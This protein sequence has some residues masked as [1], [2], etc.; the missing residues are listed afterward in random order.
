[1]AKKGRT[2]NRRAANFSRAEIHEICS[3]YGSELETSIRNLA[4]NYDTSESIINK[5]LEKGV[6]EGIV[7]KK[8]VLGMQ[9]TAMYNAKRGAADRAEQEARKAFRV[10]FEELTAKGI[11]RKDIKLQDL[12]EERKEY[13]TERRITV[14]TNA[15]ASSRNR[16]EELLKKRTEFQFPAEEEKE[17]FI[18]LVESRWPKMTYSTREF[19]ESDVLEAVL[20][21]VIAN[22]NSVTDLMIIGYEELYITSKTGWEEKKAFENSMA[23]RNVNKLNTV[24]GRAAILR[25]FIALGA[26]KKL[27]F[28]EYPWLTQDSFGWC[29][30]TSIVTPD[31]VSD[32]EA[33]ECRRLVTSQHNTTEVKKFFDDLLAKRK[34][35][36]AETNWQLTID[37]IL[38]E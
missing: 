36:Q 20:A 33:E 23:L 34:A 37:N 11:E 25:R 21:R 13:I 24:P 4:T 12:E 31:A 27:L 8:I 19:I 32:E 6:V 18:S 38:S 28:S 22:P 10:K 7:S 29:L 14:G 16:Y 17:I 3:K 15:E 2:T 5:L 9:K 35:N 26:D 1:M 30:K